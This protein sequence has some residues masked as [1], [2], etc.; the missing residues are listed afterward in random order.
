MALEVTEKRTLAIRTV[1]GVAGLT[2]L[3]FGVILNSQNSDLSSL[4]NSG[5]G[6]QPFNS[7][8]LPECRHANDMVH[9]GL[10]LAAVGIIGLICG[11]LSARAVFTRSMRSANRDDA[12]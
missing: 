7:A 3:I 5:P 10:A 11:G 9:L 1:I 2:A 4:C 6:S 12:S 8:F